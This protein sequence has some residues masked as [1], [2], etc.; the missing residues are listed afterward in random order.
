[1][2]APGMDEQVDELAQKLARL[3][4]DIAAV[5]SGKKVN[6][7]VPQRQQSSVSIAGEREHA[8][9]LLSVPAAL[10]PLFPG[11]GLV[12]GTVTECSGASSVLLSILA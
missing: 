5:A 7:I 12:R 10:T 8:R 11:G 1:M 4:R 3:R 2:S 6:S 9:D